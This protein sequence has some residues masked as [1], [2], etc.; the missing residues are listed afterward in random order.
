MRRAGISLTP[1][2]LSGCRKI[3]QLRRIA[4]CCLWRYRPDQAL[5]RRHRRGG[6]AAGMEISQI[7]FLGR[8]RLPSAANGGAGPVVG[9]HRLSAR[10][11]FGVMPG[12]SAAK[13]A[14]CAIS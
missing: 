8:G 1:F 3:L 11:T 5:Q 7:G 9:A 6:P 4:F 13:I 2:A 12:E 10:P 14:A